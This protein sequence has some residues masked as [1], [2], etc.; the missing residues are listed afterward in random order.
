[1]GV[2]ARK[3][4]PASTYVDNQGRPFVAPKLERRIAQFAD[5]RSRSHRIESGQHL[6]HF[7]WII[8]AVEQAALGPTHFVIIS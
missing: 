5:I 3:A 1:M 6:S 4:E 2:T 8:I 7:R